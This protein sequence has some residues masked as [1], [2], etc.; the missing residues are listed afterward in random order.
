MASGK[1]GNANVSAASN[2]TL[3]QAASGKVT[4]F[5]VGICNTGSDTVTFRLAISAT[6][7]PVAGE[8]IEYNVALAPNAVFERSGLVASGSEYIVIYA[9]ATGLNARAWGFEQ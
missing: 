1:L 6:A 4:T 7:T 8:Y 3:F 5:N 2:T 9:S